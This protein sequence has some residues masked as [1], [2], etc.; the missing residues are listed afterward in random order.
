MPTRILFVCM[1]NICR[2]PAAEGV[3]RHLLQ[4]EAPTWLER[5]TIDSAGTHHYH[6]GRPPDP[7]MVEAALARGMDL[8]HLR[9]RRVVPEDFTIFSHILVMDQAN[10][11]HLQAMQPHDARGIPEL[12]MAPLSDGRPREVPDPYYGGPRGFDHVLDLLEEGC[13]DLM[14]RL[15][16]LMETS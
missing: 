8:S 12:I 10:L 16:P 4:R 13:L 11:A 15:R 6:V 9:A 3:F 5:I 7:R 2:S 1:G 14:L